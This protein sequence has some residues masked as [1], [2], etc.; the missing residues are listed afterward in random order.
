MVTP[1]SRPTIL[2]CVDVPPALQL[3][4]TRTLDEVGEWQ[5]IDSGR[6]GADGQPAALAGGGKPGLAIDTGLV[7]IEGSSRATEATRTQLSTGGPR[8]CASVGPSPSV[9]ARL[10][11]DSVSDAP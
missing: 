5:G 7:N 9:G 1:N 6:I 2:D 10:A 11:P 3:G 8:V 4:R